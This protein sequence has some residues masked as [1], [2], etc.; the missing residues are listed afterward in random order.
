MGDISL[1]SPIR[2]TV[3]RGSHSND[4]HQRDTRNAVS[5]LRPLAVL[6][7]RRLDPLRRGAPAWLWFWRYQGLRT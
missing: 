5:L 4:D 7:I 1:I 3:L 6:P 2:G